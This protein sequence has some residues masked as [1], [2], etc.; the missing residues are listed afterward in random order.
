[1][2][3]LLIAIA[4]LC[5]V[6]L[7]ASAGG[8]PKEYQGFWC[9]TQSEN[10]FTAYV[11]SDQGCSNAAV[12]ITRN[13]I[14]EDELK[15]SVVSARKYFDKKLRDGLFVTKVVEKCAGPDNLKSELIND[16]VYLY[17]LQ[18]DADKVYLYINTKK[19]W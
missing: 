18:Q 2:K 19:W 1:M 11:K 8:L 13:L 4:M 16:T 15:C 6:A 3:K 9:K 17:T 10:T 5:G 14:R 12:E 7:P